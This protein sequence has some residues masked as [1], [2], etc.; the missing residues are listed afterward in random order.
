VSCVARSGLRGPPRVRKPNSQQS[1]RSALSL[2]FFALILS[3]CG[4]RRV[5]TPYL[6]PTIAPTSPLTVPADQAQA[7]LATKGVDLERPEVTPTLACV[8][9]LTFL[10]DLTVPDGSQVLP[11]STLDKRW[12]VE[13]SGT[14]NWDE[15]YRLKLIAGPAMGA[16]P[17]QALYPARSGTQA[18]L[19]I[20]F[21]APEEP[22]P[23]R[24]A[25]QAYG[26]GGQPFGDPFFIEI[27]VRE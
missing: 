12:R 14:C 5:P 23:Y 10:E 22:G 15:D 13:N 11:G 1:I 4:A 21:T 9:N 3:A 25:W 2:L 27:M 17:E 24:S 6:P 19:R 18:V 7:N 8:P 16:R 26:P 20:I